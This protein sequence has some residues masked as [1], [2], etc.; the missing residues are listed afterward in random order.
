M[1]GTSFLAH[2]V[3]LMPKS[4]PLRLACSRCDSTSTICQKQRATY[5]VVSCLKEH[6]TK[7]LS[8]PVR[9]CHPREGDEGY[10]CG[11]TSAPRSPGAAP[12]PN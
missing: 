9:A 11:D 10:S 12:V 4:Q 3:V 7:K 1:P 5:S 6:S 2:D 8:D